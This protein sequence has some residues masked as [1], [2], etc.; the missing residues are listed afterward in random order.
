MDPTECTLLERL[1]SLSTVFSEV[2]PRGPPSRSLA[3]KEQTAQ[4][5]TREAVQTGEGS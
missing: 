3:E 5:V 4:A 2:R 1:L